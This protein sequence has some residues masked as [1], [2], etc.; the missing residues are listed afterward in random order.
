VA[1]RELEKAMVNQLAD[2]A[3]VK[4]STGGYG[5]VTECDVYP[6]EVS[7]EE[8]E[9]RGNLFSFKL[10]SKLYLSDDLEIIRVA[11]PPLCSPE[12]TEHPD[13]TGQ[14]AIQLR[15]DGKTPYYIIRGSIESRT[16]Q[17]Q[18]SPA[19]QE[20]GAFGEMVLNFELSKVVGCAPQSLVRNSSPF[21]QNNALETLSLMSDMLALR[22]RDAVTERI[23]VGIKRI[24][25]PGQS[26]MRSR[27]RPFAH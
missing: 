18:A 17:T 11:S 2:P 4:E 27:M 26:R 24:E 6:C 5:Q 23:K 22:L 21:R 15:V 16:S 12:Q 1:M 20:N 19:R 3:R 10:E 8:V 14:R 9:T 7:V 13:Q 25:L